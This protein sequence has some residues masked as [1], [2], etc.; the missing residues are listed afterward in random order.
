M[1]Q[2]GLAPTWV[3]SPPGAYGLDQQ[4]PANPL[5][6]PTLYHR[7]QG[8]IGNNTHPVGEAYVT[9]ERSKE[10]SDGWGWPFVAGITQGLGRG[11][12]SLVKGEG[13]G[14]G[15]AA[16]IGLAV[17]IRDM[18]LYRPAAKHQVRRNL[19]TGLARRN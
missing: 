18:P 1:R 7:Q 8:A 6:S 19:R 10:G 17:D 3:R 14:F 15:P 11:R 13:G 4:R 16:G 12:K 2:V 9:L 5:T